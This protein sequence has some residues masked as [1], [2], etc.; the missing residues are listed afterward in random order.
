LDDYN[1]K[2]LLGKKVILEFPNSEK[3]AKAIIVAVHGQPKNKQVRIRFT[4]KGMAAS[5]INQIAE[6]KL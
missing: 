1:H 6:I 5:A 2:A 4:N 3:I